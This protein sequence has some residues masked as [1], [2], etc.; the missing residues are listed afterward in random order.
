[1]GYRV[2]V[3]ENES[4]SL[5]Y[6]YANIAPRLAQIK[7]LRNYTFERFD[8]QNLPSLFENERIFSFDSIFISTNATSDGTTLA[9]LR[10]NRILIEK[11][12]TLGKGLFVSNQKKLAV[13]NTSDLAVTGF[14]PAELEITAIERP[15]ALSSEGDI[16]IAAEGNSHYDPADAILCFPETV[17]GNEILRDCRE[18]DFKPHLYRAYLRP[19]VGGAYHPLVFDSSYQDE[20]RPLLIASRQSGTS[21]RVLISTIALD[22]E[23]HIKLITNIVVFISEGLPTVAFIS[24]AARPTGDFEYLVSSAALSKIPHS[25]YQTVD[26]VPEKL[27]DVHGIYVFSAD[28]IDEQASSLWQKF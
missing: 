5:R 21:E 16:S 8:N 14:L 3:I 12:I 25:V 26:A 19:I 27:L 23:W 4:E 7:R 22:W 15:E 6:G 18:N 9:T 2:A 20:F 28:C 10:E 17:F 24:G 13:T 11:F 1:M